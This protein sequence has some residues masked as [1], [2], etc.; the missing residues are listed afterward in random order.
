MQY[1]TKSQMAHYSELLCVEKKK[2]SRLNCP[3]SITKSF[4]VDKV[5][6][7]SSDSKRQWHLNS[8]FISRFVVQLLTIIFY[9]CPVW[10]FSVAH[11]CLCWFSL[12]VQVSI[13]LSMASAG[14]WSYLRGYCFQVPIQGTTV[15]SASCTWLQSVLSANVG[16]SSEEQ[17]LPQQ[18]NVFFEEM[19]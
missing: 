3:I 1:S 10:V 16:H 15:D 8:S 11:M 13:V 14:C 9:T 4:A 7:S 19:T 6:E 2:S 5:T 18:V 17:F 12:V